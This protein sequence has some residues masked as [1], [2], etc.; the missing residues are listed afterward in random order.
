VPFSVVLGRYNDIAAVQRLLE[1][2]GSSIAAVIVEP[3]WGT[4]CIPA[5]VQFLA[6]L[7]Q[8]SARHGFVLIFD[9]VMTSR[10]HPN[11]YSAQVDIRPDLKTLGKYVGGGMSFGAFGGRAD[12]MAQFDPTRAGALPH[13][14]TYN[15]NT[16]TMSAGLVGLTRIFTSEAC[17]SLNRRGDRFRHEL[18]DLFERYQ[19]RITATG[20]GSMVTLHPTSGP[21]SRPEDAEKVDLRLREILFLD[22]LDRGFYVARRGYMALS[23]ALTDAF[24]Q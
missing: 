4:G 24:K 8:Q 10:L 18:N 12:I 21:L 14:G 9:E 7:A 2:E 15:N 6:M 16:L 13:A 17:I 22:L 23:L 11:G 1:A 5:D 3:V 20:I 19:A